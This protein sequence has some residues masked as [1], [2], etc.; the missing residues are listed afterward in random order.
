MQSMSKRH[1]TYTDRQIVTRA[2]ELLKGGLLISNLP[3]K[4]M[5][6]FGLSAEHAD[7]LA[8]AALR[9]MR[10]DTKPIVGPGE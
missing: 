9:R 6:E 1:K 2:V 10:K 5:E 8:A 4:L 7:D 3:D